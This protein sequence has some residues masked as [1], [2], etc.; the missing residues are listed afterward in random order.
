MGPR[1]VNSA[2]LSLKIIEFYNHSSENCFENPR[3]DRHR[4]ISNSRRRSHD[5]HQQACN[6]R[7]L[8]QIAWTNRSGYSRIPHR[9]ARQDA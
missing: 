2:I 8:P 7:G 6:N 1:S 9:Q 3:S 5:A 4:S